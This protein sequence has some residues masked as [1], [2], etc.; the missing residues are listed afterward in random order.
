MGKKLNGLV[1]SFSSGGR[2]VYSVASVML[3]RGADVPTIDAMRRPGAA[4][5]AGFKGKYTTT[6]RCKGGGIKVEGTV[7]VSFGR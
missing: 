3:A 7:E 1:D 5:G 2:K 4:T 6:R